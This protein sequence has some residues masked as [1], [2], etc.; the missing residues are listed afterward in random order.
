M[1]QLG[2][3]ETPANTKFRALALTDQPLRA[4]LHAALRF[5]PSSLKDYGTQYLILDFKRRKG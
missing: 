5:G 1:V 2:A 4:E 3:V